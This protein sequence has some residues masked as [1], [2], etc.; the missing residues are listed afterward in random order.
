MRTFF[1]LFILVNLSILASAQNGKN[2]FRLGDTPPK[3]VTIPVADTEEQAVANKNPF[4][5]SP[6]QEVDV[7]LAQPAKPKEVVN[8]NPFDLSST[9]NK[10][11]PEV[12]KAPEFEPA[13]TP[14][15]E[16]N[17]NTP[18]NPDG[19]ILSLTLIILALTTLI[20]IFFRSLYGKIY[21]AIF[22]DNQL[23]LL[24]RERQGGAFGN[25]FIAYGVFFFSTSLF[26][27]LTLEHLN[28]LPQ[29]DMLKN[30]GLIIVSLL[31]LFVAKHLLLALIA[32]IFPIEKEIHVY[33]FTIM[34]FAIVIGLI[35]SLADFILAYSPEGLKTY[36]IYFIS[37]FFLFIYLLRSLRGFFIAN[38]FVFNYLFHFLLYL[39]AV[40]IAPA[41]I[42]YK[43]IFNIQG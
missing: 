34:I 14:I 6:V 13:A 39:C 32:L 38:R 18:A 33:S 19:W 12:D 21:K 35:M 4:D 9:E 40:E 7:D 1:L 42:I 31:G 15:E 3:E 29:G 8:E 23:S 22:N 20:F 17:N 30:Y 36:I 41:L 25:F 24:Y 26:I 27:Y 10:I 2:P 28:L 16:K 5:L 11:I 43:M 37:L